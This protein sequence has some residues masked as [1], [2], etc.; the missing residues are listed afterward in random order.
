MLKKIQFIIKNYSK[1]LE[2]HFLWSKY[3]L[4]NDHLPEEI[5]LSACQKRFYFLEKMQGNTSAYHVNVLRSYKGKINLDV[6]ENII[7]QFIIK[8]EILRTT[9]H[10]KD[11]SPYQK[12]NK[13]FPF[14]LEV[15]DLKD[16]TAEFINPFIEKLTLELFDLEKVPLFRICVIYTENEEFKILF[17]FHHIIWD[18]WSYFRFY[19]QLQEAYNF[20]LEKNTMKIANPPLQYQ[21]FSF[22]ERKRTKKIPAAIKDFY[23][24]YFSKYQPNDIKFLKSGPTK[25]KKANETMVFLPTELQSKIRKESKRF[26][27]TLNT[28][29]LTTFL[30]LLRKYSVSDT[31]STLMPR[32]SRFHPRIQSIFGPMLNALPVI[33]EISPDMTF[34]SI[35][36]N[37]KNTIDTLC[38]YDKIPIDRILEELPN[39]N[40]GSFDFLFNYMSSAWAKRIDLNGMSARDELILTPELPY[41][42]TFYTTAVEQEDGEKIIFIIAYQ[43][44]RISDEMATIISQNYLNLLATVANNPEIKMKDLYL[45]YESDSRPNYL[46]LPAIAAPIKTLPALYLENYQKFA[47]NPCIKQGESVVS[48]KELHQ[49]FLHYFSLIKNQ[50]VEKNRI[51][52]IAGLR[53]ERMLAAILAVMSSNMAFFLL[54]IN[55]NSTYLSSAIFQVNPLLCLVADDAT[56]SYETKLVQLLDESVPTIQLTKKPST[57]KIPSL[58]E[59]KKQ[60]EQ[61]DKDDLA[62]VVFTSGTTGKPKGIKGSHHGL[63]HFIEWQIGEFNIKESDRCA[64]I[65]GLSFDV[66]LRELFTPLLAGATLVVPDNPNWLEE[67][68]FFQWIIKEKISFFHMVPTIFSMLM[69]ELDN[70]SHSLVFPNLR[71]A[72]FAGEPLHS[73]LIHSIRSKTYGFTKIVNLYGPSETTLAKAYY[74]VPYHPIPGIQPIGQPIKKAE[75]YVLNAKD[76]LC[77]IGEPGEIVIRPAFHCLGYLQPGSR[78]FKVNRFTKDS[79]DKLFY[80]GDIGYYDF[81]G[82]IHICGRADNQIKINGIRI[83]LDTINSVIKNSANVKASAVVCKTHN[84]S[85]MIIAYL[86]PHNKPSSTQDYIEKIESNIHNNLPQYMMPKLFVVLDELP[87]LPSGKVNRKALSEREVQLP[88][89]EILVLPSTPSEKALHKIWGTLMNSSSFSINDSHFNLGFNSLTVIQAIIDIRSQMGVH[90]RPQ[91]FVDYPTLKKLAAYIDTLDSSEQSQLTVSCLSIKTLKDQ[92][93]RYKPIAPAQKA[94]SLLHEPKEILLTGATGFFGSYLLLA[95][96]RKYPHALI[97]CL[98]RSKDETEGLSRIMQALKQIESQDLEAYQSRIQV[99]RGELEDQLFKLNADEYHHLAEKIDAIYHCGAFVNFLYDFEYLKQANVDGTYHVIRFAAE[100]HLKPISYISTAGIFPANEAF[101]KIE[102]NED[103]S[104]NFDDSLNL[105]GGYAQSK[106]VAEQ[107]MH[108]A[109]ARGIPVSIYRLGR[110]S[111]DSQNGF[112]PKHDFLYCLLDTINQLKIV[113]NLAISVDLIPVNLAAKMLVEIEAKEQYQGKTYHLINP[114]RLS[115]SQLQTLLSVKHKFDLLSYQ[116]WHHQIMQTIMSGQKTAIL[117]FMGLLPKRIEEMPRLKFDRRFNVKNVVSAL[118]GSNL[119]FCKIDYPLLF[120]Y[121]YQK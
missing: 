5:P 1:I 39:K 31:V 84:N 99:V 7:N 69:K 9:F 107:L 113:P 13:P 48:Y 14:K 111:G 86:S 15:Y 53:D 6:L 65:T 95:L 76:E 92:L 44:E 94:H 102:F 26:K 64:Q 30:L 59:V 11:T 34:L 38:K 87:I 73:Q 3:N 46:K 67:Q 71:W 4:Y 32:F 110:I 12:I 80:T 50:G 79:Q 10:L 78:R 35:L 27:I 88:S 82:L 36:T 66:V 52:I 24:D 43:K 2:Q 120:K 116:E 54:D 33:Q 18:G 16:K 101:S 75:V 17:K 104:I 83:E 96:L 81:Q 100:H 19:S 42:M 47:K 28:Y 93:V 97:H 72:F 68:Q 62:Y 108:Q 58:A 51:V 115:M 119:Q 55:S 20:F 91:N 37:V 45:G 56:N 118:N 121:L 103:M 74:L 41:A 89:A 112:W 85:Q 105:Y 114:N 60:V 25:S 77:S 63:A 109:K 106:W 40:I 22:L 61:I 57:K 49:L 90:L 8:N 98:V 29:L 70:H 21:H 117:P 23:I